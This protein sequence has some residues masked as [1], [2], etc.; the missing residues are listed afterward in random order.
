MKSIDETAKKL[1]SLTSSQAADFIINTY[2][3]EDPE[4]YKAFQLI[5]RRSWKKEDQIRLALYYLA[6][7]PFA[8]SGPYEI[9]SDFMSLHNFIK[10]IKTCLPNSK[11]GIEL[12]LYHIEPIL[13]KYE[14][15][16][17][18]RETVKT[19]ISDIQKTNQC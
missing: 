3:L 8:Q 13:H 18:D 10:V 2:Q 9:F 14:K 16:L 6:K 7:M 12:V 1:R 11:Q 15:T 17:L 4:Y 5:P 19:F